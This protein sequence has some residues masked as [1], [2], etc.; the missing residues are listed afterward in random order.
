LIS[1]QSLDK[2]NEKAYIPPSFV[3]IVGIITRVPT[4]YSEELVQNL[5]TFEL[6]IKINHVLRFTKSLPEGARLQLET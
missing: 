2:I 3:E 1:S 5:S 4:Q 6:N